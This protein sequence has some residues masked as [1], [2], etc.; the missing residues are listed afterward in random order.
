MKTKNIAIFVIAL[1]IVAGTAII[2]VN[3]YPETIGGDKDDYG[4][5]TGAG[6]SYD[7]EVKACTRNWEL[8]QE[9]KEAVKIAT[10]HLSYPVTVIETEKLGE[11]DYKITLQRNDN[12]ERITT[13]ITNWEIVNKDRNF[14]TQESREAEACTMEYNPVCGWYG[15]ETKCLKYPC[16][17]TYSNPC[18]ACQDSKVAYWTQGEC[19]N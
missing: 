11:G 6:Y 13:E 18:V 17:Q 8:N 7:E 19:P 12:Q 14:C 2:A 10:A 15:T 5:L 3:Y 9:D 4:C 16:A 1:L